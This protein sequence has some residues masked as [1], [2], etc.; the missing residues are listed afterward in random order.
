MYPPKEAILAEDSGMANNLDTNTVPDSTLASTS[1]QMTGF[2]KDMMSVYN[3]ACN[4]ADLVVNAE[5]EAEELSEAECNP[6]DETENEDEDKS[7]DQIDGKLK[8]KS[9]DEYGSGSENEDADESGDE[10]EGDCEPDHDYGSSSES[11]C[12]GESDTSYKEAKPR[13]VKRK[14]LNRTASKAKRRKTSQ[15]A[16]SHEK[17]GVLGNL[18]G[19][20]NSLNFS[21]S[22]GLDESKLD[23]TG[24]NITKKH[25]ATG[26]YW[27]NAPEERQ[28]EY[29]MQAEHLN[30]FM[31]YLKKL[32]PRMDGE[33]QKWKMDGFECHF[34]PHQVLGMIGEPFLPL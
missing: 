9:Q 1:V 2:M 16:G 12:D 23:T 29:R 14:T 10:S 22:G 13:L 34:Y 26:V 31:R 7:K 30:E 6:D 19:G 11:E 21:H 24:V 20:S 18:L 27:K 28:D 32:R 25:W 4:H 5:K 15:I 8:I 17:R 3:P 33:T